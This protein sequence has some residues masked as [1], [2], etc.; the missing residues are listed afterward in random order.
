[1]IY[2]NLTV[3]LTNIIMCKLIVIPK[4]LL[5]AIIFNISYAF[6][7]LLFNN[8]DA[9]WIANLILFYMMLILINA[10]DNNRAIPILICRINFLLFFY[11]TYRSRGYH[12]YYA[13]NLDTSI[14]SNTIGFLIFLTGSYVILFLEL[15]HKKV[16]F[17][18]RIAINI[19][20]LFAIYG[21]RSRGSLIGCL[22]FSIYSLLSL[23][24]KFLRKRK[25]LIIVFLALVLGG[26]IFPKIYLNLYENNMAARFAING[27]I[28]YSGREIIWQNFYDRM[29]F[30]DVIKGYGSNADFYVGHNLNMHNVYLALMVNYGMIGLIGFFGILEYYFFKNACDTYKG[31]ELEY[32]IFF[33]S[34]LLIS[35][36]EVTLLWPPFMLLILFPM[37]FIERRS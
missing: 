18:V 23:K 31:S 8:T 32:I 15:M 2:V 22:F 4:R 17:Y 37:C 10:F 36:V 5:A 27:K 20:S 1:M 14:N 25:T 34:I 7:T 11:Y 33:L 12:L 3:L 21:T 19:V 35:Y 16:P 9:G 13:N 6:L 28:N 29:N 24:I 26:L 30:A